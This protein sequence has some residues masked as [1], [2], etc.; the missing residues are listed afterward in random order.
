MTT[1]DR[2][3]LTELKRIYTT[4]RAALP[5]APDLMDSQLLEDLQKHLMTAA[6]TAGIDVSDHGEWS[7]W[8]AGT[9]D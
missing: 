9:D 6:G 7:L 1:F 2:Y 5:D 4:L 8:L 3:S